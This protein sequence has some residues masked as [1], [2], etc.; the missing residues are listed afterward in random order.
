[1]VD[2]AKYETLITEL[3]ALESEIEIL[4]DKY[5]DTL[6]RNK[7]LEVSLDSAQEDKNLLHQEVSRLE[8]DLQ[9]IKQKAEEKINLNSEERENFKIKIN[10]LISRI[11]YHLSSDR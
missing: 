4:N 7:E 9:S 11:N 1:M 6:E 5:S 2:L 3:S 10:D 8:E